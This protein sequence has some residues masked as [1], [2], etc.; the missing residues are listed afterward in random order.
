MGRKMEICFHVVTIGLDE[1]E[2]VEASL[3]SIQY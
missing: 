2:N 3:T 1:S